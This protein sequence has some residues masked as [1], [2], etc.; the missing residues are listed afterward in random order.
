MAAKTADTKWPFSA[1]HVVQ[2]TTH[3][4][5]HVRDAITTLYH[6]S[7]EHN[8]SIAETA[9]KIGYHRTTLHRICS[10]KYDGDP[11]AVAD[12]IGD[13]LATFEATPTDRLFIETHTSAQIWEVAQ[14]AWDYR[15]IAAVWGDSH[16]GKTHALEEFTRRHRVGLVKYVRLPAHSG[17]M[18]VI[19]AIAEAFNVNMKGLI[20]DVTSRINRA[21]S[22]DNLVIVDEVHQPFLTYAPLARKGTMEFIRELYD[23][24]K[25]G[26]VICGTNIG[27]DGIEEGPL[28]GIMEQIR[29]RC[30]FTLQLPKYATTA[31]LNSIAHHFGLPR[32]QGQAREVATAVIR[33]NGLKTYTILLESA[34]TIA[35]NRQEPIDWTL[36]ISAHDII[37]KY[38]MRKDG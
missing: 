14:A 38:A 1:D 30:S 36:F 25:C 28:K 5:P 8:L 3:Y 29:R 21:V 9:D 27:R 2:A 24:T 18:G 16:I 13:Y 37:A 4:E 34:R 31:D 33:R 20:T 12:A 35:A 6:H 26:M 17:R 15:T 7:I 10:G 22:Q 23:R 19:R 11:N 32:L